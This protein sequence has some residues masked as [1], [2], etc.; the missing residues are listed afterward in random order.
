MRVQIPLW[1]IVTSE[2][3]GVAVMDFSSNSSMV[4]SNSLKY[5]TGEGRKIVQ[6]PLWSIVTPIVESWG[7]GIVRS[8]SS[9]VDSNVD[10]KVI[11]LGSKMVQIPLWS[12]VTDRSLL[13]A[14]VGL[15]FKFLYGR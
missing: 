1:S 6:I 7:F 4:D 3:G 13:S 14:V 12:I 8:N 5:K 10:P 9:M 15:L 2:R 11:P